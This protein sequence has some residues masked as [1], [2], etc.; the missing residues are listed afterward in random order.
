M[1]TKQIVDKD[2]RTSTTLGWLVK[3]DGDSWVVLTPFGHR[4]TFY[5]EKTIK[6]RRGEWTT[7]SSWEKS[8]IA[9][10]VK[11]VVELRKKGD[12]DFELS[13]RGGLT[14]QF[15]GRGAGVYEVTLA[16]WLYTAK[17]FDLSARS[18]LLALDSVYM[19]HHLVDMMRHRVGEAMGYKM[20]VAFAGDRDFAETKRLADALVQRYPETRFHDM[21]VQFGKEMPSRND[22]FKKLKLPTP[23]EWAALKKK[24]GRAEQ[25][26]YLAERMRLLNCFQQGQ[27]G[28][29]SITE[30]QF[31]EPCGLSRN[32]A[33][34]LDMGA[35]QSHQSLCRA[36][37]RQRRP[38]R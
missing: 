5:K 33:W 14:G 32:A 11:R 35:N 16:H 26:G 12:P 7:R 31:A 1:T 34:G 37:G 2:T 36:G 19:D 6:G 17:Q 15:Q 38:L 13:E 8:P 22:D 4:E 9:D 27:P 3:N 24:L 29:Y 25:I 30:K 21:A 20:L 23:E 28:G 18:C 10:E